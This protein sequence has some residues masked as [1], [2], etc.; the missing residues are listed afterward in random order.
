MSNQN[1]NIPDRVILKYAHMVK[2]NYEFIMEEN[3]GDK[4]LVLVV[5][6]PKM[7]KNSGEFDEE[8]YKGLVKERPQDVQIWISDSK[9]PILNVT[10]DI[11]K[12]FSVNLREGFNFKNYDYL[13]DIDG[14]IK[15][16]VL[17]SSRPNV[18]VEFKAEWDRPK[19]QLV[20]HNFEMNVNSANKIYQE[21]LQGILGNRVD[22]S[23]YTL[24]TTAGPKK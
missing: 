7:D 10:K 13:D 4:F 19:I 21:E 6:C 12:F 5:D 24:S 15:E 18:D 1:P 22:L 3:N 20:F 17:K 14:I 2:P 23:Q 8:Y 9:W 16:A 11:Q